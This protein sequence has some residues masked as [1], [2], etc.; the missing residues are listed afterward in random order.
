MDFNFDDIKTWLGGIA[1]GLFGVGSGRAWV[2]KWFHDS[3]AIAAA[4]ADNKTIEHQAERIT[5]LEGANRDLMQKLLDAAKIEG[6]Q[7]GKIQALEGKIE[8]HERTI[9]FLS[10]ENAKLRLSLDELREDFDEFKA[11]VGR[12]KEDVQTKQ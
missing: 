12:R 3:A 9:T 2:I 10:E 6:E 11:M 4:R 7:R 8:Q 5:E 1:V